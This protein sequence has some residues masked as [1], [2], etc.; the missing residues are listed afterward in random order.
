ML[1]K[2]FFIRA[3]ARLILS[4]HIVSTILTDH[5]SEL[6]ED[7]DDIRSTSKS[8][9]VSRL[10]PVNADPTKRGRKKK[11]I[12][13]QGAP[14]FHHLDPEN[15]V[16]AHVIQKGQERSNYLDFY[17]DDANSAFSK[18]KESVSS[19]FST[20]DLPSRFKQKITKA[21]QISKGEN[22]DTSCCLY[23]KDLVK[24]SFQ[25]SQNSGSLALNAFLRILSGK[26]DSNTDTESNDSNP[27]FNNL[28]TETFDEGDTS[29]SYF[30]ADDSECDRLN[31]EI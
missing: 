9:S 25:R 19:D 21:L 8:Y 4:D 15:S 30:D 31:L 16:P 29:N 28:Q 7:N 24:C 20:N 5:Y 11:R 13:K 18:D 17:S 10:S 23:C 12:R 2:G 14:S 1:R 22:G 6:K 3:I 27:T 26:Y